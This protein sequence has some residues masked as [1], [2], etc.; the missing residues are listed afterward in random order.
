L[1][2]LDELKKCKEGARDAIKWLETEFK[3]G[4]RFLRAQR[5]SENLLL[6]FIKIPNR[7]GET[8]SRLS[9]RAEIQWNFLVDHDSAVFV[10]IMQFANYIV[11]KSS[12]D[13][14]DS[15]YLTFLT[16]DD[17]EERKKKQPA[18]SSSI[19]IVGLL[20]SIPVQHEQIL[21][22]YGNSKKKWREQRAVSR[23]P[24]RFK[25]IHWPAQAIVSCHGRKIFKQAQVYRFSS[26]AAAVSNEA[27]CFSYFQVWL[28]KT[29]VSS[30]DKSCDKLLEASETDQAA[31]F[32]FQHF[33]FLNFRYLFR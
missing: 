25:W 6:P 12:H 32:W 28:K 33:Y 11:S 2:E 1:S 7:I 23:D 8:L 20:E 5:D 24:T 29:S 21:Q 22:F 14:V 26:W 19:N 17:L 30:M 15:Q 10:E 18:T 16:G 9:S 31:R 4:N 3:K 27:C 13:E